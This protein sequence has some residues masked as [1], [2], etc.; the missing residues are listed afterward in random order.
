[1][2]QIIRKIFHM[3]KHLLCIGKENEKFQNCTKLGTTVA[4]I[5]KSRTNMHITNKLADDYKMLA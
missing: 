2:L 3:S 1:M 5:N 4:L